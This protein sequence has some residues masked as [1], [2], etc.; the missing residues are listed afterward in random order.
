MCVVGSHPTFLIWLIFMYGISNFSPRKYFIYTYYQY[1]I[2]VVHRV[3]NGHPQYRFTNTRNICL[4][5]ILRK[6]SCGLWSSALLGLDR[7]IQSSG[8]PCARHRRALGKTRPEYISP[9]SKTRTTAP[10]NTIYYIISYNCGFMSFIKLFQN[11]NQS[12]VIFLT[13]IF[14]L[15]RPCNRHLLL[16]IVSHYLKKNKVSKGLLLLEKLSLLF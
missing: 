6:I 10:R 15:Y 7:C 1:N 13:Q 14:Y 4:G 8:S 3:L 2:L 16:K 9:R 11:S 5:H 12:S